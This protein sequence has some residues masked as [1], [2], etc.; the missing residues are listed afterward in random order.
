MAARRV[1]DGFVF[2]LP[3][4]GKTSYDFRSPPAAHPAAG[5]EFRPA[6]GIA[7]AMALLI[8]SALPHRSLFNPEL[9]TYTTERFDL[10]YIPK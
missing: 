2:S 3:G 6:A 5:M 7:G 4:S 9:F 8:P 1:P 10:E